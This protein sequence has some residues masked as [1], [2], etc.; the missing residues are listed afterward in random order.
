MEIKTKKILTNSSGVIFPVSLNVE[1]LSTGVKAPAISIDA[2]LIL[3]TKLI[4]IIFL[5]NLC[6]LQNNEFKSVK[7]DVCSRVKTVGFDR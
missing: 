5:I 3:L 7:S 2:C 6:A 4:L 1:F